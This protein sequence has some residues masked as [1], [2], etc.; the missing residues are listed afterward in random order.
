[1]LKIN[2]LGDSITEGALASKEENTYVQLVGKMTNSIVRNYGISGSRIA[3]AT[4]PSEDPRWD[5]YFGSRV[6]EMNHDADLVFVF[7]G[8]NDFGHHVVIFGQRGDKT[9]DTFCGAVDYLI[10]KLLQYFKK[11]QI[12]FILPLYC[13]EEFKEEFEHPLEEFR[14][15][16]RDIAESYGIKVLD[17]KD[18]IGKPLDNP[19]IADG[20]HPSDLGHQRIAE[21]ISDYIREL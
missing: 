3:I 10:N 1:M 5:R 7:G 15:A 17:I 18:E 20:L 19:Y 13:T 6:D 14:Q 16:M 11:E 21:L 2:F 9:P 8:T 12:I 4:V